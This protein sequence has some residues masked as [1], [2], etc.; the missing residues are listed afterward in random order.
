MRHRNA[1]RKQS[2][3]QTIELEH[4]VVRFVLHRRGSIQYFINCFN[5]DDSYDRVIGSLIITTA[6]CWRD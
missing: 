5:S 1:T 6:E 2:E 4:G 3:S